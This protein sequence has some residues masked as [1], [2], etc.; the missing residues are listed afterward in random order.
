MT[1]NANLTETYIHNFFNSLFAESAV[2]DSNVNLCSF[3]IFITKCSKKELQFN[4]FSIHTHD[5]VHESDYCDF[6]ITQ[7][8]ELMQCIALWNKRTFGDSISLRN[9]NKRG[10][11]KGIFS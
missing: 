9:D 10:E 11:Q 3:Q 2:H 8:Y 7:F 1:N 5:W 4:C 6:F